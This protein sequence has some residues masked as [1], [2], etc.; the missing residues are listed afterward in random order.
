MAYKNIEDRRAASKRHYQANKPVY[1]KRNTR[2]RAEIPS[3]VRQ[4]KESRPCMDCSKYFPYYV[5]D[6]DHLINKMNNISLLAAT[7]RIA[8][9]KT[10]IEK[11]ELVCAN[12]HRI[13]THLRL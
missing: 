12:Y 8:A 10:E 5:M 1:L 4:T 13:R 2:Y 6:F 9:V 11:C 7:G 3:Y